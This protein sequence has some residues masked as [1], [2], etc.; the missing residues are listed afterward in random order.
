MEALV[1][2]VQRMSIHD[3]PGIRSTVFL[4]GCNFRCRWC[5]NPETWSRKPE[6]QYIKPK[7]IDCGL[8][9]SLCHRKA[10]EILDGKHVIDRN[11]CDIC[12]V[13][14]ENCPSGALSVVGT[15][16]SPESLFNTVMTDK[17]F[18][19]TSGGG[20]TVSGGE[21]FLQHAFLKTFLG[22]CHEQG[23]HTAVE[24]NLSLPWDLIE[25]VLDLVSLWMC[26]LKC[27]DNEKHIEWTGCGNAAV[28][29][30]LRK[31]SASGAEILVRTPVIPGF[32]DNEEDIRQICTFLSGLKP[33]V[34]YELLPFHVLGFGKF[35]DLGLANPMDGCPP[36][37]NECLN[38]LKQV[39]KDYKF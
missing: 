35:G 16:Y 29:E 28:L 15:I 26:D 20:V 14:S 36:L 13:C 24:T 4:K 19:E 31:L 34:R 8:C 3:G 17:V 25:D 1:T 12:G 18:Y 38:M 7:C 5:H 2:A 33:G 9:A 11:S 37:G 23:L 21:P 27:M 30:N 22:M 10:I 39:L 32:N 6:L